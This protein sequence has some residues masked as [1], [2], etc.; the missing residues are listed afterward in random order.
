MVQRLS[1]AGLVLGSVGVLLTGCGS[2]ARVPAA[3]ARCP[4]TWLPAPGGVVPRRAAAL[5]VKVGNDP[6][7]R[8]RSG[9]AGADIV[10]EEPV[11]RAMTRLIAVYQCHQAADVGPVRSTRWTDTRIL[12]QFGRAG[13]AFAGGPSPRRTWCGPRPWWT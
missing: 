10:I 13:F 12:G 9:L 11:E 6:A 3:V 4:L 1:V 2:A 7:A 8:P 5:A